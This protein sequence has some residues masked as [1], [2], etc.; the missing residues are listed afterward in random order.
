MII[1]SFLNLRDWA[2]ENEVTLGDNKAI[3]DNSRVKDLINAEVERLNKD[4]GKWE[5]IK[6]FTLLPTEWTI[7]GGELTPTM[8]VKR[9][10][11]LEKYKAQ[12][13]EL[14]ANEHEAAV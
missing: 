5:Q 4:F 3:V 1:P 7:E 8:K 9:K 13:V 14:Y 11:I 12:V 6:K 2:K 10:I